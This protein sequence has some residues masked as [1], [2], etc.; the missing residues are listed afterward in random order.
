LEAGEERLSVV[1]EFGNMSK[2][3]DALHQVAG[4]H[5]QGGN[6]AVAERT[7]KE[8]RAL[9]KKA[10]SPA[11]EAEITVTLAHI[12][13]EKADAAGEEDCRPHL[14]LAA[15]LGADA[16]TVA[17]KARSERVRAQ[18]LLL[19]GRALL[20]LSRR[21]DAWR[22]SAEAAHKYQELGDGQGMCK[23]LLVCGEIQIEND[24]SSSAKEILEQ[25]LDIASQ[26]GEAEL[27][28][29]AEKLLQ[30]LKPKAQAVSAVQIEA[31][32]E[33]EEQVTAPTPQAVS[34]APE[35]PKG[36]DPIFVRKQV[37]HFVKDAIADDDEI[38]VDS[39]FME[40]GMDSLSSVSLTSMLAKEFGMALSPSLVFDFP[41]IRA[42]EAHLVEES[43]NQ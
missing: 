10:G 32:V 9:A 15:R 19:R 6:I 35:K 24:E 26:C 22:S 12:H 29:K 42:L 33:K 43:L 1:R 5:F 2:E 34:A 14:E 8:A 25:A 31:E 21:K 7:I 3:A 36:L 13:L 28:E 37:L 18:A 20:K 39:P 27:S 38:E 16:V 4:L 30:R 17:G 11:V 41:T 40:A 23:A